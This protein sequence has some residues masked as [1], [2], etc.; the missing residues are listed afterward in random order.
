MDQDSSVDAPEA[1][2]QER[3]QYVRPEIKIMDEKDVLN[4]F[5]VTVAGISWW[6]M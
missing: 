4:A 6:G 5:Q 1:P 2:N 3:P